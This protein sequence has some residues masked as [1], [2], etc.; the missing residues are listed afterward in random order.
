MFP[1]PPAARARPSSPAAPAAG[2][3]RPRIPGSSRICLP[4]LGRLQ[5][6]RVAALGPAGWGGSCGA[7][8]GAAGGPGT[9]HPESRPQPPGTRRPACQLHCPAPPPGRLANQQAPLTLPGGGTVAWILGAL[10]SPRL[11]HEGA[12][13]RRRPERTAPQVRPQDGLEKSLSSEATWVSLSGTWRGGHHSG[14]HAVPR[15]CS[16]TRQEHGAGRRDPGPTAGPSWHL[17]AREQCGYKPRP[18]P[19]GGP[20]RVHALRQGAG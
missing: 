5:R 4:R 9:P 8:D 19:A 3:P 16:P 10:E 11:C 20:R 1:R 7:R 14:H 13:R 15:A 6:Q 2:A 18:R 12:P 17:A